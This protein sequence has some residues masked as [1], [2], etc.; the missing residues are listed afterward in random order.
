MDAGLRTLNARLRT[1]NFKIQKNPTL[2]KQ[3]I[4][5]NNFIFEFYID[6]YFISGMKIFVW[7]THFR[8]LFSRILKSLASLLFLTT[9]KNQKP[10]VFRWRRQ[11]RSTWNGLTWSS[12]SVKTQTMRY[13]LAVSF[14][15]FSKH[16]VEQKKWLFE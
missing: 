4:Y 7:C 15:I 16:V 3:L 13:I 5:I 2:W 14:F 12:A 10:E 9:K 1:L 6:K 8:S 11:G